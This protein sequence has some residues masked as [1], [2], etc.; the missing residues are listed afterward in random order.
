VWVP[1]GEEELF[2]W[3]CAL[4]MNPTLPFV[5]GGPVGTTSLGW[6]AAFLPLLQNPILERRGRGVREAWRVEGL[7]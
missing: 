3:L 4:C 2:Q 7:F 1:G 6:L 5:A